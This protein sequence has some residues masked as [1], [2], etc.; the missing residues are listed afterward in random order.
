MYSFVIVSSQWDVFSLLLSF[1][2]D[3]VLDLIVRFFV[4]RSIVLSL[5]VIAIRD[6]SWHVWFAPRPWKVRFDRPSS[7]AETETGTC[8][9]CHFGFPR[10]LVL[11]HLECVAVSLILSWESSFR[12]TGMA[13]RGYNIFSWCPYGPA[14]V[15]FEDSCRFFFPRSALILRLMSVVEE[16][17][18]RIK[19]KLLFA[20]KTDCASKSS[21]WQSPCVE[22]REGETSA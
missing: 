7:W 12:R 6:R 15:L 19:S 22:C 18:Y 17:H 16:V 2:C 5:S 21:T 4:F 14:P 9:T 11:M 20:V 3:E 1:L 13:I 10:Y 8:I